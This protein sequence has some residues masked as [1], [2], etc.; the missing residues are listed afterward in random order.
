MNERCEKCGGELIEGVIASMHGMFFYP[1][2][3]I[4]KLKPKRSSI[5]CY[6]CKECGHIQDFKAKELQKIQ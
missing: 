4:N 1:N 3:E 6:C 5:V 2:G